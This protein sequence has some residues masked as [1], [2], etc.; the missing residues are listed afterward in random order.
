[1]DDIIFYFPSV[2]MISFQTSG[3]KLTANLKGLGGLGVKSCLDL[4]LKIGLESL[5][6]D[7]Q[8]KLGT[9]ILNYFKTKVIKPL[10][11]QAK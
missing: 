7:I 4:C 3:N 9:K 2:K 6:I 11:S 1:M 8:K 5:K 10:F